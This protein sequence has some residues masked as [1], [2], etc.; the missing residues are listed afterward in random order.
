MCNVPFSFIFSFC[1][2]FVISDITACI[3]PDQWPAFLQ[4]SLYKRQNDSHGARHV[5]KTTTTRCRCE[6]DPDLKQKRALLCYE[7]SALVSGGPQKKCHDVKKAYTPIWMTG[8]YE[9]GRR[10]LLIKFGSCTFTKGFFKDSL[11]GSL[12]APLTFRK[13][14]PTAPEAK[15]G[16]Y[17]GQII[18]IIIKM[19]Q[20]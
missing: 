12:V 7:S 17:M 9:V 10:K 16:R 14:N 20:A 19:L 5:K 1:N 13:T 18:I 8:R 3:L 11:K 4:E 6:G 15:T 2:A